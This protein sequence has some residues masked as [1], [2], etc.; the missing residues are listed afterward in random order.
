MA[1]VIHYSASLTERNRK[2][3][4]DVLLQ[5][6]EDWEIIWQQSH[7]NVLPLARGILC[8]CMKYTF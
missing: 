8:K 6:N 2:L 1:T 7:G 5:N 3:D 4:R